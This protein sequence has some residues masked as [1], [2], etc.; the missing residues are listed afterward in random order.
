MTTPAAVDVSGWPLNTGFITRED[1]AL[2]V[3]LLGI[4]VPVSLDQRALDPEGALPDEDSD[5]P[6]LPGTK[7]RTVP[8]FF[9][10]PE[11]E[12]RRQTYPYLTIDFLTATRDVEREH[13]GYASYGRTANAYTPMGMPVGGGR[14]ELPIPMQLQYQITTFARYNQHDRAINTELLFNRLEPRFGFLEMVALTDAPDDNSIRRLDLLSGPANGD[15]RD[16]QGKRLFRKMY[17]VSVSSELFPSD[18]TALTGMGRVVLNV[19]P[20]E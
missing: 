14:T 16:A 1:A 10:L 6:F 9:R 12:V 7:W 8:V 2:K 20:I 11:N 18:L 17:T 5:G 19:Y 4:R 15:G 3:K 13:R